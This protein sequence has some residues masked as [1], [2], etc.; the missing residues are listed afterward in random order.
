MPNPVASAPPRLVMHVETI[1]AEA[2]RSELAEL[3]RRAAVQRRV[4]DG[5]AQ[6]TERAALE[7]QVELA[8]GDGVAPELWRQETMRSAAISLEHATM[9]ERDVNDRDRARRE[10]Q[11]VAERFP[12]TTFAAAAAASAERLSA[13]ANERSL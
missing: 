5:L 6:T 12:G 2:L 4:I 7:R 9:M 10:Y 1:D 11:L 13:N 8:R 3:Q